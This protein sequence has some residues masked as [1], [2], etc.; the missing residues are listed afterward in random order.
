[1]SE[2]A[3][4]AEP[5]PS[6]FE[7]TGLRKSLEGRE[8]Y[9]GLDLVLE[10]GATIAVRGASGAGKSQLLRH[11]ARLDA[12]RAGQLEEDGAL[13]LEGRDSASWGARRWR[14]EVAFVPQR[15]PRLDGAPADLHAAIIELAVQAERGE[16]EDPIALLRAVGLNEDHWRRPWSELSGGEAQRALLAVVLARRP[17]VLLLD[18]PTAALDPPAARAVEALLRERTCVWVTHSSE[19]AGR[20][21]SEVLWIGEGRDAD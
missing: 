8:L 16:G 6:R 17:R 4:V 12:P 21:A 10:P 5:G 20:V 14:A 3:P 2:A 19:Q 1:M 18:E 7:A 13:R 9:R 11:L 15:V